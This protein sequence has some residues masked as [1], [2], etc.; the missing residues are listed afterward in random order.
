MTP[1][2]LVERYLQTRL[3]QD[4]KVAAL[5]LRAW[6]DFKDRPARGG[7]KVGDKKVDDWLATMACG[8][9]S[10]ETVLALTESVPVNG[11]RTLRSM[12]PWQRDRL[13]A[14]LEALARGSL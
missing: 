5:I 13:A 11:S 2:T 1:T 10:D 14:H 3:R 6:P 8:E 4:A 7:G 12:Q 9:V